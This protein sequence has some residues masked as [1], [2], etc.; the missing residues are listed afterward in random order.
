MAELRKPGFILL[1][2]KQGKAGS[3]KVEL[4]DR[5]LFTNEPLPRRCK[6]PQYRIRVNGKWYPKKIKCYYASWQIKEIFWRSLPF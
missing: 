6:A 5:S 1:L 2:K 3:S 4:F